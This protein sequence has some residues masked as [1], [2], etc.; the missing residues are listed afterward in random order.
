MVI[1]NIS[2]GIGG[3]AEGNRQQFLQVLACR[4][5]HRHAALASLNRPCRW[6][7]SRALSAHAKRH[8]NDGL[9]PPDYVPDSSMRHK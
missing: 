6:R 9:A 8:A 5:A 2:G 3:A 4:P 1:V 7:L